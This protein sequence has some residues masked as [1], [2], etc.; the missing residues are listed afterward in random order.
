MS[1]QKKLPP[2]MS[3]DSIKRVYRQE[4]DRYSTQLILEIKEFLKE[5]IQKNI[6]N[7]EVE[8]FPD[9]YGDGYLSIG[10]YLKGEKTQHITFVNQ[11]KDLPMIDLNEY[12]N[13]N[14]PDLFVY[15]TQRWFAESWWKAGG[16]DYYLPIKL[17][18]HEDF[19]YGE[20]INLTSITK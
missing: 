20:I 4:L 2:G 11:V 8:I 12:E 19:G 15:L 10:L 5:P 14:L 18:G 1:K 6:I 7:G 13:E 16:W 9:E 3:I 17:H